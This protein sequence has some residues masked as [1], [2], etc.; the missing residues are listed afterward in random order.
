[1]PTTLMP[2]QYTIADV[3]Q[4][5]GRSDDQVLA[6]IRNK[7]LPASKIFGTIY[8]TDADM[9]GHLERYPRP[10][11]TVAAPGPGALPDA[12]VPGKTSR[13]AGLGKPGGHK[14]RR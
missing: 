13:P 2:T 7:N 3:A 5:S 1:M 12:N 9:K 6:D 10:A 4:A 11:A 8:V 14:P